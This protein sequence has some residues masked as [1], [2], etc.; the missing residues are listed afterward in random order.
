MRIAKVLILV[1]AVTAMLAAVPCQAGEKKAYNAVATFIGQLDPGTT[2]YTGNMVHIRDAR[3]FFG[4]DASDDRLDGT[5]TTVFNANLDATGSGQIWGTALLTNGEG[6]WEGK[7]QGQMHNYNDG[8]LNWIVKVVSRGTGEYEGLRIEATE[9]FDAN[10]FVD[11]YPWQGY[12]V[13]E[14][15]ETK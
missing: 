5:L 8:K 11:P 4:M 10:V 14:I 6:E 9:A 3:N 13:G 15:S 7:W 2:T 1:F 12:G